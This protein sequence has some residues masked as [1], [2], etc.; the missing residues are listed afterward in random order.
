M[1]TEK[2]NT[3]IIHP[4]GRRE[5]AQL[6]EVVGHDLSRFLYLYGC[7]ARQDDQGR[8]VLRIGD[9][10][11]WYFLLHAYVRAAERIDAV[12][13]IDAGF[14]E[15]LRSAEDSFL[16][17]SNLL[18]WVK[19]VNSQINRWEAKHIASLEGGNNDIQ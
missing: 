10:R 15:E 19:Y 12:R 5:L 8:I 2:T 16:W 6:P 3:I 17:E 18:G 11:R 13:K 14:A 7:P 1:N 9:Y 4:D